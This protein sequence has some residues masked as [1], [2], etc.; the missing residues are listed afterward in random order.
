MCSTRFCLTTAVAVS[1]LAS[2]PRL[3]AA[4]G[5]VANL[6]GGLTNF[7]KALPPT[8]SGGERQR[9][10]YFGG[11]SISGVGA[12]ATTNLSPAGLQ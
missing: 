7:A 8:P 11:G 12:S 10:N 4:E 9:I 3:S 6:R 1:V 2:A 5:A